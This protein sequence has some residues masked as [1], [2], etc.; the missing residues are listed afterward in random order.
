[1]E[2][3]HGKYC[4]L[5]TSNVLGEDIDAVLL[6]RAFAGQAHHL[7]YTHSLAAG[8][9]CIPAKDKIPDTRFSHGSAVMPVS[10]RQCIDSMMLH[11]LKTV[12]CHQYRSQ[13]H[14]R[15]VIIIPYNLSELCIGIN[16]AAQTYVSVSSSRR[17][18]P[19][20]LV[21]SS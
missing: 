8:K 17:K 9:L 1:M 19:A 16:P 6:L 4:P 13:Q 12:L 11:I 14:G 2:A 20:K 3:Q 7:A 15:K 18:Y 21:T 10:V 5:V